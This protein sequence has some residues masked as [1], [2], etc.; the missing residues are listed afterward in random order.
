MGCATADLAG[1]LSAWA[2]TT[3]G[4]PGAPKPHSEAAIEEYWDAVD[5]LVRFRPDI[6]PD[7]RNM[8][9]A[10]KQLYGKN[11]YVEYRNTALPNLVCDDF[12]HKLTDTELTMLAEWVEKNT[13]FCNEFKNIAHGQ[14]RYQSPLIREYKD[15]QLPGET[16]G[17]RLANQFAKIQC[18]KASLQFRNGQIEQSFNT[19][20]D[21]LYCKRIM[22]NSCEACVIGLLVLD[23]LLK[24]AL[25]S[26]AELCSLAGKQAPEPLLRNIV[27]ETD[28]AETALTQAWLVAQRVE[29]CYFWLP[30]I[31]NEVKLLKKKS[32]N[33][34]LKECIQIEDSQTA[35]RLQRELLEALP[36]RTGIDFLTVVKIQSGLVKQNLERFRV[37]SRFRHPLGT[38][39]LK[40]FA[41]YTRIVEQ[42]QKGEHPTNLRAAAQ[43]MAA[44]PSFLEKFWL[45]NQES[46]WS[47]SP[48]KFNAFGSGVD[49]LNEFIA[50]VRTMAAL[51]IF[52][53][54]NGKY[55]QS[56]SEL[57]RCHILDQ[58]PPDPYDGQPLSYSP[59]KHQLWGRSPDGT[60]A[61]KIVWKLP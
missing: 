59:E 4:S 55:P 2:G 57:V 31:S 9:T 45:I 17:R 15:G 12:A 29:F 56:L 10:L 42:S 18:V 44:I 34:I 13:Q 25:R 5:P 38:D 24:V 50:G 51:L 46:P 49:N 58:L 11:L 37:P 28:G 20:I 48:P 27:R 6:V 35:T 19:L 16:D 3:K 8:F 32:L 21:L 30:G 52:K 26:L 53:K 39:L 36:L 43:T 41:P 22:L 40:E 1:A 54:R 60:G 61:K 47:E 14:Y 7:N 23:T 33:D